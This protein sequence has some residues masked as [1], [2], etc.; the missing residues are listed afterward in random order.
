M[1]SWIDL[2]SAVLN[3]SANCISGITIEE[4]EDTAADEPEII[5]DQIE[6]LLTN[7][8]KAVAFEKLVKAIVLSPGLP[9]MTSR[10][11]SLDNV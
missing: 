5:P 1:S 7:P 8:L 10:A 6:R 9:V 3:D 11:K 4:D 2:F